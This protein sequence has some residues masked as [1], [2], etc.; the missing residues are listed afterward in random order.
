MEAMD[1]AAGPSAR[2]GHEVLS[3]AETQSLLHSIDALLTRSSTVWSYSV[4][5]GVS[6]EGEVG[7]AEASDVILVDNLAVAHRAQ[8]AAHAE[9]GDLRIL[10]RTTVVGSHPVDPPRAS[11]LPPF[12]YVWGGNPLGGDGLWTGS[13]YYGV[14]FRWNRSLPMRN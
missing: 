3:A 14:G 8:P 11:G 1:P 2:C 6:E 4:R 7:E 12:A 10:H 13:D 9:G 5:Y